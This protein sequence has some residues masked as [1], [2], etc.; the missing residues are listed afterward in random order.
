MQIFNAHHLVSEI[1][2]KRRLS[3]GAINALN[4]Y[5]WS[6][7][8]YLFL[9]LIFSVL[10]TYYVYA[11]ATV[12]TTL[13]TICDRQPEGDFIRFVAIGLCCATFCIMLMLFIMVIV[14]TIIRRK[15]LRQMCEILGVADQYQTAQQKR[16]ALHDP[17][18]VE[19]LHQAAKRSTQFRVDFTAWSVALYAVD[20][21]EAG[22][23]IG[24]MTAGG[25][26]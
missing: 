17:L 13:H 2:S 1:S 4:S 18:F 15:R 26:E 7:P 10:V 19:P 21:D 20:A 5:S 8:L 6:S 12:P 22:T 23:A 9:V 25:D 14:E 3:Y 16:R 11:D 24:D